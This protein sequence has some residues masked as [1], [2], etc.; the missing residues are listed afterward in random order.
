M[1][2]EQEGE[3]EDFDA[4][5]VAAFGF[6]IGEEDGVVDA[7]LGDEGTDGAPAG[8]IDGDAEE[9]DAPG[10]EFL[11]DVDEIGDLAAAGGAPGGP[12]VEE[13]E[14]AA[15]VVEGDPGA[16]VGLEIGRASWWGRV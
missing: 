1:A 4:G 8:F 9:V 2:V 13:D 12:E 15:E 6:A 5:A 14:G 11:E 16:I 3:G 10:F 7:V